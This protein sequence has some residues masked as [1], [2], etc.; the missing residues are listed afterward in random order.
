MLSMCHEQIDQDEEMPE[1]TV[2]T[3]NEKPLKK[4]SSDVNINEA[5]PENINQLSKSLG[6]VSPISDDDELF[7]DAETNLP[8]FD[9]SKNVY[10]SAAM[11]I[12]YDKIPPT[13]KFTRGENLISCWAMRPASKSDSCVFEWLLCI[14]LKGSLPKYVLNS[15]SFVSSFVLQSF[16]T[17]FG[18]FSRLSLLS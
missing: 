7:S 6:N 15:V 12:D 3:E 2:R 13:S 10:V 8:A 16:L 17:F 11:S 5:P 14:D 4:A 18:V 9:D 1:A